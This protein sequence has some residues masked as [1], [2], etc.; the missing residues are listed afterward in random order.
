MTGLTLWEQRSPEEAALLNP[1]FLGLLLV[2]GVQG[3]EQETGN[4][5]PFPLI[6]LVPP[7][8]LI[9]GTRK[10]LPRRKDSSLA[11]W[12]QAHPE[13]RLRFA[14]IAESLVPVV[15]ESLVFAASH[16]ALVVEQD[17][18]RSSRLPRGARAMI[19]ANTRDVQEVLRKARFVGKW[20]AN[21]GTLETIMSLWGVRP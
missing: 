12:L 5:M 6:F 4:G 2:H 9:D 16:G 11:A 21:A 13:V 10:A 18:V 14:E 19:A 3:Y 8:V 1:A 17:V 15:R 7:V 20:Y